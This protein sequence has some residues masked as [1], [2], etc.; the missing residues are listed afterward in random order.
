MDFELGD[1]IRIEKD[2]NTYEGIVMPS[3]TDH[4]VVKMVSGY[5]AG[6]D[7]EGASITLLEKAGPK[8]APKAKPDKAK[9]QKKLPKVTIL[10]TGGTIASKVDYR[11]GAV[12]AQFSADDIV[13]AIPE[14]TEIAD[15][16]GRV[17]YNIL[18]E[19]MKAEYWTELAGAVAQEIENGADG[20][21]IAHGTDTM[22]Y[23]AAALSFML[24]TP[25]PVVFVGSQRSADRP[26]SD[27]AMN[28][29]CAT[30]VAVS[31]IA[32]VCVVMH[33][34]TSDDRCAIHF[35]TK[36]R[37]M[38]TS[39]RDAFQSINSDPIG[40]ID[41]S[42][43]KIETVLPFSKRDSQKLEL[44]NTL[45]PKCSLVKFV[46]GANP[47]VLSYYIDSGYKGLVIEGTGLG[48]VSTDWIPNIKRAT[49]NGI[50]VIMT[51]QC[52][53]GRVCDRVYDTGRD[54]LKAG[55]IEG[56]DMLPEVALVKLMWA[57]GQ[58]NDVDEIKE[59]MRSNIG[60]EM[61]DS[62]LK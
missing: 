6:V 42:T 27:N 19:N 54:I 9:G 22:M 13:D 29:I 24:K 25:V 7:P 20:I 49:E 43:H 10:S 45:E 56:E 34:T 52:I 8:N 53:S 61:T 28:A 11:T 32:E 50:P 44:K 21:I 51:S 15:I 3:N 30:K 1:R 33:D 59:I 16:N 37:K 18:S 12:T 36:V 2:G 58:S 26:S 60:H 38:H 35:G 57:L 47:D 17:L 48:H 23:S 62:T 31:D 5:N 46:P 41:H 39:R 4:I 55:A 14:L 40:Y